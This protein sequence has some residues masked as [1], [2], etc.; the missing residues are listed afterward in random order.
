M[1]T[2]EDI[3]IDQVK[4]GVFEATH[5]DWSSGEGKERR[6]LRRANNYIHQNN[7]AI[8]AKKEVARRKNAAKKIC[9]RCKGTG[10][11]GHRVAHGICFKCGGSG[12]VEVGSRLCLKEDSKGNWTP[13]FS[14][15]FM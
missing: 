4:P 6:V 14:E 15:G 3:K 8:A 2:I 11:T 9:S 7:E 5:N 12:K 10:N 13:L 1:I